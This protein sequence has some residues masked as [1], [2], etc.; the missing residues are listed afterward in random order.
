MTDIEKEQIGNVLSEM[1]IIKK[2]LGQLI[3][4]IQHYVDREELS[5]NKIRIA[6]M[7]LLK[8]NKESKKVL[9]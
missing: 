4:D 9:N 6:R 1:K 5:Q 3:G 2:R 7:K 8:K